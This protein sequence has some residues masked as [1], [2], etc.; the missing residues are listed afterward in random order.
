MIWFLLLCLNIYSYYLSH[1]QRKDIKAFAIQY[2]THKRFDSFSSFSLSPCPVFLCFVRHYFL[3]PFC[4]GLI[5]NSRVFPDVFM[6][7]WAPPDGGEL[8]TY[9][10]QVSRGLCE[11]VSYMLY[12]EL[13]HSH[14]AGQENRWTKLNRIL[15]LLKSDDKKTESGYSATLSLKRPS[16]PLQPPSARPGYFFHQM[17]WAILICIDRPRQK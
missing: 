1:L 13:G 6:R 2:I 7:I 3:Q 14:L 11:P 15:N 10:G 17:Q 12:G 8:Y 5:L 9:I 16:S 4:C